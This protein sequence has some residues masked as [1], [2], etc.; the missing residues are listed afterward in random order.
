MAG[1]EE[2]AEAACGRPPGPAVAGG[3]LGM[4]GTRELLAVLEVVP[5]RASPVG[6]GGKSGR[7][8]G[9]GWLRRAP[10]CGSVP[11]VPAPG[12]VVASERPPLR[13]PAEPEPGRCGPPPGA[14]EAA[15]EPEPDPPAEPA[16]P[17]T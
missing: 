16:D 9:R 12:A 3:T 4:E 6:R 11:P 15:C 17:Y 13:A 8:G 14:D 2:D 1:P 7:A 5:G 10:E